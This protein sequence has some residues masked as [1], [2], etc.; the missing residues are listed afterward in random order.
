MLST[1]G[2]DIGLTSLLNDCI[3]GWNLE[4]LSQ[5]SCGNTVNKAQAVIDN[6]LPGMLDQLLTAAK[7]KLTPK[8]G[9]IY[10]TAYAKFFNE[11]DEQCNK[12]YWNFWK[13]DPFA[14][15]LDTT[16][17][18]SLNALAVNLNSAIQAA[19]SRA[20]PQ[21]VF[22]N[23]DS[24]FSSFNGRFCE[25]GVTEPAPERDE[26]L[27]FERD[28]K[29]PS[30]PWKAKRNTGLP[31]PPFPVA[32]TGR[33]L[34]SE[35]QSTAQSVAV[36]HAASDPNNII[37]D[38]T[39]EGEIS[40]M[41]RSTLKIHPSWVSGVEDGIFEVL[42]VGPP[43]ADGSAPRII[44]ASTASNGTTT[45]F[46][47]RRGFTDS[48]AWLI[49]DTVKRVFH[50]RPNGHAIIASL[51]IYHMEVESAKSQAGIQLNPAIPAVFASEWTEIVK[52]PSCPLQ[53]PDLSADSLKS[54][55]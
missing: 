2:N 54:S 20:G 48:L 40:R 5:A 10:F 44:S 11:Q 28:T 13:I 9:R 27:F 52:S 6:I 41:V 15:A 33:R 25:V 17:R 51:V 12:V 38:G 35:P 47:H 24:Y 22:V 39:F 21:V 29:N 34:T 19:A 45:V 4:G 18:A 3:F 7:A 55:N 23:Y 1:G 37:A 46:R 36:Q 53:A 26:L 8:T 50:P 14:H 43:P 31:A 16:R 30:L 32:S 42:K 49:P